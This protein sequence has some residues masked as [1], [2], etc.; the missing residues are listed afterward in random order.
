MRSV[1]MPWFPSLSGGPLR[2]SRLVWRVPLVL[3]ALA[4]VAPLLFG[5]GVESLVPNAAGLA[6]VGWVG[7]RCRAEWQRA[8]QRRR[9]AHPQRFEAPVTLSGHRGFFVS[10]PYSHRGK[11]ERR[12]ANDQEHRAAVSLLEEMANDLR[13]PIESVR[14]LAWR[15]TG[16]RWDDLDLAGAERV[17][18]V[19]SELLDRSFA[20]RAARV[21]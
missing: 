17:A 5:G 3:L 18:E 19:L 14:V 8:R 7:H 4:L 21:E 13:V 12:R 16:A 1:T 6:F 9:R 11:G 15:V 2:S 10:G 20:R